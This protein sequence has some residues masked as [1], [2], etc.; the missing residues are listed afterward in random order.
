MNSKKILNFA[1]VGIIATGILSA[2]GEPEETVAPN[3]DIPVMQP[4]SGNKI[5]F[6]HQIGNSV[7]S[8]TYDLGNYKLE[9]WRITDSKTIN[10][11]VSV[12]SEPNGTEILL[13]HVHADVSIK[14]TDPQLNGL[15]QDSM[16]N[17]YHG[18]SQDGFFIN[19]TYNYNNIFAVE[20]FSKDIIDGWSFYAGDYGEGELESKRL[21]EGNLTSRG[22]YG[23]ELSIVYNFLVK[24]PGDG[25]YHIESAVDQLIIPTASS[26]QK[27]KTNQKKQ[28][29][30]S[31]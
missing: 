3:K 18:T 20:G 28:V 6:D 31:K 14:A 15:T 4:L 10:M 19:P 17:Q 27:Q 30:K 25:K 1:F 16:D 26:T 24:N 11:T 21:T 22:A 13:D 5:S 7:I 9:N 23:S 8:T 29:K 12:K 2:C